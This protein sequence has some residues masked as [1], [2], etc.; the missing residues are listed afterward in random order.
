MRASV[1]RSI[2]G[3]CAALVLTACR[4]EADGLQ[5]VEERLFGRTA[6]GQAVRLFTLRNASGMTAG[7]MEHGATIT[8]LRV[9]DRDGRLASVV[10]GADSLDAYL[11]GYSAAG[12]VMGR[13]ANRIANARFTLDG[14]EF[15]VTANAGPHQLH[16]GR[17]GFGRKVWRGETVP[18]GPGAAAVRFS[19]RSP[20]GEEGFPGT[21]DVTVTYTLSDDNTLR[22]DYTAVTD[23]PTPVNLTNHAYFN[24]AGAGDV[25]GHLVWIAAD[26]ITA[27]DAELIPTGA[28]AP[29][30]GTPL[31]F[32]APAAIGAR[33]EALVPT[34]RGYDHNFALRNGGQSFARAAWCYEP[35][36]GRLMEVYT[37][38]P[39]L[40]LY[41]GKRVFRDGKSVAA[42]PEQRHNTVC[43][44][45]Q[46][47][48][49]S[50]NQPH[51][52]SVILRPGKTFR[53]ATA[54][55]FSV[56]AAPPEQPGATLK[57]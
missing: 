37:D 43:F 35:S 42:A 40:Q 34:T 39:G 19:L 7:V 29:V 3:V 32:T 22:L 13:V 49:D 20:D 31:D 4:L 44:E 11:R 56:A 47:F 12:A 2:A 33:I 50:V 27:A 52:P 53:S 25:W 17:N 1:Y 54:F 57:E 46:H 48:P 8:G 6:E 28:F 23:K 10:L 36:S 14:R 16:G 45:T 26:R 55:R 51:F 24:L 18:A 15:R 38:Q 41:T 21:L 9:P 5:R 30:A